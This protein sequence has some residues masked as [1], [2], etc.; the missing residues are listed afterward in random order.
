MNHE[1]IMHGKPPTRRRARVRP[2][3]MQMSCHASCQHANS[4]SAS[5]RHSSNQR[6]ADIPHRPLRTPTPSRLACHCQEENTKR[7][8]LAGAGAGGILTTE[9]KCPR[10]E[11]NTCDYVDSG[12]RDMGK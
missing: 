9:Y 7:V 10:C 2:T 8:C 11:S 1:F 12:R 4:H 6:A 3:C 5:S